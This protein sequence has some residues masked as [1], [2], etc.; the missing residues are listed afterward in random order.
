MLEYDALTERTR[1]MNNDF[2][3]EKPYSE[4]FPHMVNT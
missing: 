4:H 2:P 3:K 1:F